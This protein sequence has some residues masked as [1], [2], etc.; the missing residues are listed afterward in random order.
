MQLKVK[1]ETAYIS[2]GATK[3]ASGGIVY[4]SSGAAKT[5][6]GEIA[7]SRSSGVGKTTSGDIHVAYSSSGAANLIPQLMFHS[8]YF[9]VII[10]D[11][12]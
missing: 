2:S 9:T 6:S 4:S 8:I 1:A 7:Y 11:S 5:A 3:P 10:N 12:T